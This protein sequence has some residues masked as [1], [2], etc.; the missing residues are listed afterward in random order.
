MTE[1][2]LIM[3]EEARIAFSDINSSLVDIRDRISTNT[4]GIA[5]IKQSLVNQKE[6]ASTSRDWFK[7]LLAVGMGV[8]SLCMLALALAT[9]LK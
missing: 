4:T 8:L 1:A 3:D 7:I 5:T 6:Q 2:L 9:Y